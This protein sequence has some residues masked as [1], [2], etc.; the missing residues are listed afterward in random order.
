MP[1]TEHVADRPSWDCR[2]CGQPW[3]CPVAKC[4]LAEQYHRF[5][6]GL[7][8]FMASCLHEAIEDLAGSDASVPADL[9]ERFLTWVK[10][11]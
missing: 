8:I 2:V 5:P 4:Q 10:R 3:P 6:A 1:R 11:E 9:F 7:S